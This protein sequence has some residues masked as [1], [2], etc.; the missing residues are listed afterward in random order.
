[1][2]SNEPIFREKYNVIVV[3]G[4]IA[5]VAAS[6][7]ASRMGAK[8]LLLEKGVNLGGLATEGLISWYEP[9]C[10]G[11]GTQMIS[12]IAEELIKLSFRYGFDNLPR[13]WGG[14]GSNESKNER[15]ST[16]YSPTVFA[17][18]LDEFVVSNNV[19]ILFDTLATF[20]VMKGNHCEGVIV[21]NADGRIRYDADV[22]ID[23]TGN[24]TVMSRAGVPTHIGENYMTYIAH[25][26]DMEMAKDLVSDRNTCKF[27]KWVNAGSDMQGN[28][29]PEG[30]GMLSG[31]KADDISAYILSGKAA[32]LKRIKNM[33]RNSFDIMALPTM[34]QFRTI[35]RIQGECDFCAEDGRQFE[36]SIGSCGD[37]RMNFVGK[38]YNV[39]YSSLYN[40]NF[41]NLLAAGRIISSPQGNGWEVARVIP[42]CALTGEAAGT[43]A[44]LAI[45]SNCSVCDV[46]IK[47]LQQALKNNGVIF[48]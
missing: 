24:A 14:E 33:D 10:D 27:R 29:H 19:K 3:G 25:Y 13:N 43:A 35:R 16:Y 42:T 6:V 39:P 20:P 22:V 26:Y 48:N 15:Y 47:K 1:M 21:E 44:A 8:T 41:D 32:M 5:G 34:A 18:A 28:G 30:M 37:F 40:K 38:R 46:N 45:Q 17:L 36:D 23:A 11:K 4:G 7:S 12:S 31:I 2:N 9:L